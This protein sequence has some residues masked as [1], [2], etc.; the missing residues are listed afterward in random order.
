[1]AVATAETNPRRTNPSKKG[2]LARRN[3]HT[4]SGRVS[5]R[6]SPNRDDQH[7]PASAVAVAATVTSAEANAREGYP[8]QIEALAPRDL[9]AQ[10]VPLSRCLSLNRGNRRYPASAAATLAETNARGGYPAQI[11][12]WAWRNLHLLAAPIAPFPSPNYGGNHCPAAAAVT[13]VETNARGG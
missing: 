8:A 12:P 4:L 5:L 1:M 7:Y 6:L 3:L 2:A 11:G 10:T 9:H 13:L